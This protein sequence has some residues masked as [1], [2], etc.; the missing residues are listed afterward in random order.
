[1]E[2]MQA[3][4]IEETGFLIECMPYCEIAH[5]HIEVLVQH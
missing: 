2:I 3:A 5:K 1:M 4:C